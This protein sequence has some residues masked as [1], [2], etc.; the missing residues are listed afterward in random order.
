M[1]TLTVMKFGGTSVKDL[2]AYEQV[3]KIVTSKNGHVVVVLSAMSGVTNR[4]VQALDKLWQLTENRRAEGIGSNASN[5]D[6]QS[7]EEAGMGEINSLMAFLEAKHYAVIDS[8]MKDEAVAKQTKDKINLILTRLR[9]ILAGTLYIE[10]LS[11]KTKDLVLSFGERLSVTLF[12]GILRNKGVSAEAYFSGHVGIVSDSRFG[13]ASPRMDITKKNLERT[14]KPLLDSGTIP[15]IT[16]YFAMD[17]AGDITTFGRGGSDFSASIVGA[18]LEA[19]VVEIWTDVDG[20]LSADPRAVPQANILRELNYDEASELAY[21]GAKVLHPRTI[22]P[23]RRMRIPILIKN[24]FNPENPGSR[25]SGFAHN[26]AAGKAGK[27]HL[28]SVAAKDGLTIIKIQGDIAY[29]PF[30][31][32]KVLGVLDEM[33]LN[34]Y[35]ISTSLASFS[36]LIEKAEVPATLE[37]LKQVPGLD[38]D[39]ITTYDNVALICVVGQDIEDQIGIAAQIFTTIAKNNISIRT[40]SEGASDV[41]VNFVI[42]E[43]HKAT[44][45][46]AI[47]NEYCVD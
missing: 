6:M 4:L 43:K 3:A 39:R 24:T 11:P 17:E 26:G 44:A 19:D 14:V 13:N 40:I 38:F 35:A 27:L 10:E 32:S 21:F 47:H 36:F 42:D 28:R 37:R 8:G 25:V 33:H 2:A 20:F 45:V 23:L 9:R 12:E 46:A 15:I 34:V 5:Q 16:G 22:G 30:F 7:M 41:A 29:Q 31:T 1:E 18:A